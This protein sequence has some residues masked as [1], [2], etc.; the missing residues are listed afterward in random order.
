MVAG[1]IL[2]SL[3]A[4]FVL[5]RGSLVA[6]KKRSVWGLLAHIGVVFAVSLFI[7]VELW[8]RRYASLMLVLAA[9]HLVIDSAKIAADRRWTDGLRPLATFLSDQFLHIVSI[10]VLA[11][12]FGYIPGD[13]L[14]SALRLP[15]A[16]SRYLAL[17]S[18]YIACVLGGSIAVRLVVQSFSALADADRPGLLKAGAYIGIIERQE[19][20]YIACVLGGSI[21]VRLVVQSFS[22]LADADRPGLLKAG[23]Y[24]GI[25]ER[26]LITSLVAV[27]QF[28]A[29]GFVLAAKSVARYKEMESIP[30]FA[31][32]YLIGT[33]TSSTIGVIGGML[34]RAIWT[35]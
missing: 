21:A 29:V 13:T 20:L 30:R 12:A 8:S 15:L 25:I 4:D 7:G 33:L 14:I 19:R 16:D 34:V 22:A 2:A 27:N 1:F 24:I 5:Q 23:A 11:A 35:R 31:E 28:G 6:W 10:V 26:L 32:Y 3:V 17:T 18:V 9:A